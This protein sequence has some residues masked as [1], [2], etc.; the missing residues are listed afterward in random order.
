MSSFKRNAIKYFKSYAMIASL[1]I[2]SLVF[3][4]ASEG[5]LMSVS[6]LSNLFR[7]ASVVGILSIG[8][9]FCLIAKK[10]DLSVGAVTAFLGALAA[11]LVT[12]TGLNSVAAIGITLLA[13]ALIGTWNGLL[14]AY[15]KVP[16]FIVSL[17]SGLIFM[18]ALAIVTQ[19]VAIPVNDSF[20]TMLGQS[21][22]PSYAGVMFCAALLGLYIILDAKSKAAYRKIF[23]ERTIP[24]FKQLVRYAVIA[25]SLGL[26]CFIMN[27]YKGI[28]TPVFLLLSLAAIS[29]FVL[30]KTRFARKLYAVGG[31]PYAAELSGINNASVTL[32]AFAIMGLLAGAAGILSTAQ[33]AQ[34]TPRLTISRELDALASSIVGGV[35][36][37]GGRGNVAN[38]M[39]GAFVLVSFTNGM[40]I[41]NIDDNFQFIIKGL[42]LILAVWFDIR[43]RSA[44]NR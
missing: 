6:G 23:P 21:Y 17:G 1:I 8:M 29:S 43:M 26:F 40:S 11:Y 34:A 35:S 10:F 4:F 20:F 2:I 3:Q 15:A 13:G 36:L 14:I 27:L 38:A 9:T 12:N 41:L 33:F 22:L 16:A 37:A 28:P 31:N 42:I 19:G 44:Q 7:Q 30:L 5:R 18:S 24:F 32:V 39:I 25:F